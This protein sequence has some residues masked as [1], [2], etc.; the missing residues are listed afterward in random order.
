M[1]REA[2]LPACHIE[3]GKSGKYEGCKSHVQADS[4]SGVLS[5]EAHGSTPSRSHGAL[6]SNV[7][8]RSAAAGADGRSG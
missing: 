2:R 6:V 4:S 3:Y 1:D 7:L 5:P 8:P